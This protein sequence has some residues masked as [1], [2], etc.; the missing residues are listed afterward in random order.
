VYAQLDIT[1]MEKTAREAAE[2]SITLLIN[3]QG[4]GEAV[5]APALPLGADWG[6]VKSVLLAGPLA[7]DSNAM[8]GGYSH[9]GPSRR[10]ADDSYE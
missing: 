1:A 7:G 5:P 3:Q 8:Q 6:G 2:Q 4:S 10:L 9:V